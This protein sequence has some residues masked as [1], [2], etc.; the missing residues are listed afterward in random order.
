VQVRVSDPA[1]T[2]LKAEIDRIASLATSLQMPS[3]QAVDSFSQ[4]NLARDFLVAQS[5]SMTAVSSQFVNS[6][7]YDSQNTTLLTPPCSLLPDPSKSIV[8]DVE[9]GPRMKPSN[10]DSILSTLRY[11]QPVKKNKQ[12]E[13]DDVDRQC[14]EH[15]LDDKS[16]LRE[17]DS[18]K[19]RPREDPVVESEGVPLTTKQ[20][21]ELIMDDVFLQQVS[22][23]TI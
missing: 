11:P 9:D 10:L 2:G 1:F 20:A 3:S 18:N 22:D 13:M 8:H 17:T 23:A 7:A 19:S 4:P 15:R 5:Q 6:Q 16:N 21:I 14:E 12:K